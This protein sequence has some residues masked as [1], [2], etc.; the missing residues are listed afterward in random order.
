MSLWRA[1]EQSVDSSWDLNLSRSREV[2]AGMPVAHLSCSNVHLSS[3][4]E[5]YLSQYAIWASQMTVKVPVVPTWK[6]LHLIS[7]CIWLNSLTE[8][9]GFMQYL[10]SNDCIVFNFDL[11]T[12]MYSHW[13][14][15]W[16]MSMPKSSTEFAFTID[17]K[18]NP[19]IDVLMTTLC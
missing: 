5:H 10:H 12:L 11:P 15:Q 2:S 3:S 6:L 7:H 9:L 16:G 18:L 14:L 8:I 17:N 19:T 4:N 1:R 13:T